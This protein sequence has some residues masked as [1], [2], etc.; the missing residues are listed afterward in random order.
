MNTTVFSAARWT[1]YYEIFHLY[2]NKMTSPKLGK[3]KDESK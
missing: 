2:S 1:Q 3:F